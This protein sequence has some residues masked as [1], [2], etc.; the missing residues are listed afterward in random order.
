MKSG[1]GHPSEWV[2]IKI[3]KRIRLFLKILTREEKLCAIR[4]IFGRK[5]ENNKTIL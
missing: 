1:E 2:V 3:N 4:Q 5:A